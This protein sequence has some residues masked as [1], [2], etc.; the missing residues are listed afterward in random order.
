M[1]V[2]EPCF[3]RLVRKINKRRSEAEVAVGS[4]FVSLSKSIVQMPSFFVYTFIS[5]FYPLSFLQ[6]PPENEI[7]LCD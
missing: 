2:P 4:A 6:L 1:Q 5:Y 3:E 7:F